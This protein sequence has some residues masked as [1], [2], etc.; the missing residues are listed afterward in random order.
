MAKKLPDNTPLHGPTANIDLDRAQAELCEMRKE[1]VGLSISA[2]TMPD[3][4]DGDTVGVV[5]HA[6]GRENCEKV[7]TAVNEIAD[8]MNKKKH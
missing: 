1:G 2:F 5:V 8:E 3:D 6:Q 4:P 7:L